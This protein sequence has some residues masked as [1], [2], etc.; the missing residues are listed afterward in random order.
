M[1]H[2]LCYNLYGGDDFFLKR[3]WEVG[4]TPLVKKYEI[5]ALILD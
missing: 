3:R 4:V 2:L 5:H 1:D